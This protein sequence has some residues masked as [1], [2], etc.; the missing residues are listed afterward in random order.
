MK[1]PNSAILAASRPCHFTS[2]G[3]VR[4]SQW[5]HPQSFTWRIV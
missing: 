1:T 3:I 2:N 4:L 5:K